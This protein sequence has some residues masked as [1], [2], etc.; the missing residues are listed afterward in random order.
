M[1]FRETLRSPWLTAS[2]AVVAIALLA[3]IVALPQI[4]AKLAPTP[5][6]AV[7]SPS[8]NPSPSPAGPTPVPTF[9]RPTPSPAPT[10]VSYT[11]R[12]GDTLTSIAT[13]YRTTARS[14]AWWNR[15]TYPSLDPESATYEPNRIEIGW[16]L[17]LIP[18][19]VVDDTNPPTPSPGPATPS[20]AAT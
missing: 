11:V 16:T 18:G 14:I 19:A 3:T 8:P 4:L 6:A 2:L 7:A 9:A 12:R 15:G 1:S 17:V 13:T 20:P 10:F 5:S